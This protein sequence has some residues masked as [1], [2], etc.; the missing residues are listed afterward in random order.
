[1]KSLCNFFSNFDNNF[2]YFWSPVKEIAL[3][4]LSVQY[5][6][7]AEGTSCNFLDDNLVNLSFEI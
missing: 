6:M 7:L 5:F 1:M 2:T 4:F 3:N